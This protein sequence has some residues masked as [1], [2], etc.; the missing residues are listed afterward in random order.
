MDRHYFD[1]SLVQKELYKREQYGSNTSVNNNSG[2][3]IIDKSFDYKW[4]DKSINTLLKNNN[5]IRLQLHEEDTVVQQYVADYQQPEFP[6]FE[7]ETFVEYKEWIYERVN[8]CVFGY[9]RPLY[10]FFIVKLKDCNKWSIVY[11]LHYILVDGLSP[12]FIVQ[13]LIKCMESQE[14][15]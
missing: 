6:I 5:I 2:E 4:I 1:L 8:D 3:I 14:K 11:H 15:I 10:N 13:T 7:F 12:F 9:D